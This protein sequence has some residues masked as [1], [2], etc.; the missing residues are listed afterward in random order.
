[1]YF[2]TLW[3]VIIYFP[4]L[5]NWKQLQS[6]VCPQYFYYT[7]LVIYT[8]TTKSYKFCNSMTLSNVIETRAYCSS[9]F[10]NLPNI[11]FRRS[12]I[13]YTQSLFTVIG[14]IFCTEHYSNMYF[15]IIIFPFLAG[16]VQY[17]I[18]DR[19][20]LQ[21]IAIAIILHFFILPILLDIAPLENIG[22]KIYTNSQYCNI[23]CNFKNNAFL[24]G[25]KLLVILLHTTLD[26]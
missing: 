2:S 26:L 1:M 14:T 4:R 24:L 12:E 19:D 25:Y 17:S 3:S 6:T 21:Y 8:V 22:G 11:T 16:P 10:F 23:Y 18:P 7:V 9:T 15:S 13:V 5:D 20:E